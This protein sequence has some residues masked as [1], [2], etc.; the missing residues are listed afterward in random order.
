MSFVEISNK[1]RAF[2]PWPGIYCFLGKKRLK[3]FSIK[4]SQNTAPPGKTRVDSN[5]LLIGCIDSTLRLS[6]VQLEGK[7]RSSD[8]DLLNGLK[9]SQEY[10]EVNP[11][12]KEV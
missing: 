9:N 6:E 11:K 3:V 10:F 2:D 1:M 12:R 4:Q 5:E 7:K 8:I